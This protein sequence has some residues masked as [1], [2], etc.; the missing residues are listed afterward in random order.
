[1]ARTAC[2]RARELTSPDATTGTST[3][4]TSSAVSEWSASPVYICLAE[5]G[6]SVSDAA[7]ASTSRGPTSRHVRDPFSSPRRILTVTGTETE[8][9]TADTIRQARSGS[10]SRV[11]PAP[12]FVTFLTGQP[13]LMSTRSAPA[14]STIRAA[15]A[16]VSGSEPKI[17]TARGCSSDAMRRYPSVRSLRW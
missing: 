15:S 17:W 11:A 8:P 13:K 4:S 6:W 16:I 9:A 10:S 5:R 14:S 3:R 2:A 12:V 7:P 1:M